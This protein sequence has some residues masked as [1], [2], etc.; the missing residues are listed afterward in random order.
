M[1]DPMPS[2]PQTLPALR[3]S[4]VRGA[5]GDTSA[6]EDEPRVLFEWDEPPA[7]PA[8]ASLSSEGMCCSAAEAVLLLRLELV[9]AHLSPAA[10]VSDLM[11]RGAGVPIISPSADGMPIISP[12][13]IR[14]CRSSAHQLMACSSSAPAIL[15]RADHQPDAC[16]DP[17]SPVDTPS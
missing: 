11:R 12:C 7:A 5:A 16:S 8:A 10:R 17:P 13:H 9:P 3:L 14:A 1:W 6:E 2:T 4:E 15:G